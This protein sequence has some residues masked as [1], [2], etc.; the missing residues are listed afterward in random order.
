MIA[1][2]AVWRRLHPGIEQLTMNTRTWILSAAG[3]AALW[4]S[5]A[6]LA[7]AAR[8]DADEGADRQYYT[9]W[10]ENSKAGYYYRQYCY[11]PT[12]ECEE[13]EYN[14]VIY[15][16][17][18]PDYCFYY[19]PQ[20]KSYYG[21][22]STDPNCPPD[23]RWSGIAPKARGPKLDNIPET[24]FQ[25]AAAMPTIPQ[26]DDGVTVAALPNDLPG[27]DV[28][29]PGAAADGNPGAGGAPGGEQPGG[30]QPGGPQPGGPQPGAPEGDE[31]GGEG[32]Q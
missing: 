20:A 27:G 13:Y 12:C 8:A 14:Y 10:K 16:P 11:K 4:I 31:E 26:S 17:S 6:G 1:G 3:A 2:A 5:F 23:E 9:A 30:P 24:S 15:Y 22:C 32:V 7:G 21:R 18:R 19:D 28:A 29:G 25:S